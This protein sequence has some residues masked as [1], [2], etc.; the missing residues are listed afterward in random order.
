[1][2]YPF[3]VK[4]FQQKVK[5]G[6]LSTADSDPR[7]S[8]HYGIPSTASLLA[9]DSIQHL[10]A[11]GSMDG[12]VKVF[13]GDGIE[14]LLVSPKKMPFKYVEFLQN[15]GRIVGISIDN[16]IQVWNLETRCIACS[17]QWES[18][19]TAFS[20]IHGSPYMYNPDVKRCC[21]FIG[22]EYGLMSVLK[23]ESEGGSLLHMPYH[24]SVDSMSGNYLFE[25]AGTLSFDC[26]PIVGVLPQPSS[27]GSRQDTSLDLYSYLRLYC[28]VLIAYENGLLILWDVSE[29]RVVVAKG[30]KKLQLKETVA[31][32]PTTAKGTVIKGEKNPELKDVIVDSATEVNGTL[33][34][35]LSEQHL[36]DKE[37]TALCWGS[38]SGSI[39]AVGYIDGDILFWNMSSVAS[40][41]GQQAGSSHDI[42]VKLQFSYVERR[43]PVIVLHWLANGR[44]H[45]DGDGQ[46]FV[47]GGGELGS[48]EVLTV[49]NLEWSSGMET[50][51]SVYHVDLTLNG[52][53]ADMILLHTGG[54]SRRNQSGSLFVL[55]NPGQLQ[56]YDETCLSALRCQQ[57]R[58]PS[59]PPVEYST[60]I[61]TID[62]CMTVVKL[63]SMSLVGNSSRALS[64]IARAKK[65]SSHRG[66]R[67]DVKW[68]LIGG[69]PNQL[70]EEENVIRIFVSGYHDGSVWIWNAT[71]SVLSLVCILEGEVDGERVA[72]SSAPVSN[73]D[74][75]ISTSQLAVGHDSGLVCIYNLLNGGS[76]EASYHYVTE[77]NSTVHILTQKESPQCRACFCILSSPIQALQ[78]AGY[79]PRLC[80]GFAC[81]QVAVFDLSLPSVLYL[82]D[83]L[84]GPGLP[85]ISVT[86]RTFRL[87]HR[88]VNS[89]KHQGSKVSG[90]TEQ[91][92]IFVLTKDAK[93]FVLDGVTDENNSATQSSSGNQAEQ[94]TSDP[95][96]KN[97]VMKDNTQDG[98]ISHED[99]SS[100]EPASYKDSLLDSFV[101]LC[102]ED[103]LRLYSSKCVIQG[104]NKPFRKVKLLAPCC[105]TTIVKKG[106]EICA[107]VLLY[108]TGVIEIRSLPDLELVG[109]S[110]LMSIL[111]WNFKAHMNKTI[112]SDDNGHIAL[113]DGYELAFISLLANENGFR[114]PES[115]PE[116]HDKV[117][118]AAAEAAASFSSNQ[119]KKK[120]SSPSKVAGI[121]KGLKKGKVDHSVENLA[122]CNADSNHLE[123]I[124]LK[125]PFSIPSQ[126]TD[127][128]EVLEPTSPNSSAS[129]ITK[130]EMVELSIDDIEIDE[131]EMPAPTLPSH[132]MKNKRKVG[133]NDRE[134]LL[135][136]A[137]ADIKPRIR[138]PE[139]IMAAYRKAGDAASA[140]AQARNRLAERQH[141][142][143]KISRRAE[144]L[145]NNAENFASLADELVKV[146]ESRKW[147]QI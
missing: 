5:H 88:L 26:Q 82:T 147:W 45:V 60:T 105:W 74:F 107:L 143:E 104:N 3:P 103:A 14:G 30:G 9:Y 116:L 28:R 37:I 112:S 110:S 63:F 17:L 91:E 117:L 140:A 93:V 66:T 2:N 94:S 7:I 118:A 96:L 128:Q 23:Y 146:M 8:I 57:E 6:G 95:A 11:T 69:V 127:K 80:A 101:L 51:T 44:S 61:P 41:K 34:D 97:D 21:L 120:D 109:E 87:S 16:N 50:L 56:Y 122:T 32:Y 10:L 46:L 133:Q 100:S 58:N 90:R 106:E 13:G 62:P 29:A 22:D 55:T 54:I 36:E 84:S 20:V 65:I 33:P 119:K 86:S 132:K 38:S 92:I 141:K 12:K 121:F 73:L 64:E 129:L 126:P 53:F 70:M 31:H 111:R 108:Q 124:F 59:V 19:I 67:K 115:L 39:L 145:Q 130:D 15:Q 136:G 137:P 134:K 79:G 27:S 139:E 1:H 102:C 83:P 72:G 123:G 24:I 135:D 43:L 75:C 144:D 142:L 78:F 68:P 71:Y 25:G 125:V 99:L 49:L 47:Y 89:T 76:G 52:S 131:P 42:V 77:N 81:G 114:I 98:I 35:D 40:A 18:N 4:T 138:T 48:E 85:I 113:V